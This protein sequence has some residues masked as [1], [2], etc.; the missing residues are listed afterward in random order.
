[1]PIALKKPNTTTFEFDNEEFHHNIQIF[2]DKPANCYYIKY[3]DFIKCKLEIGNNASFDSL[4]SESNAI[5]I[6]NSDAGILITFGI[7]TGDTYH[8][9][10]E[11]FGIFIYLYAIPQMK[12]MA[13]GQLTHTYILGRKRKITKI[14]RKSM[15]VY[16]NAQYSLTEA[17]ALERKLM[18]IK[19][20]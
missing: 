1:M 12:K 13:E 15:I 9:I 2:F 6:E 20:M 10:N 8:S 14:G 11:L 16:K 4:L 5:E 7:V 19:K 18:S 17:K 3:D